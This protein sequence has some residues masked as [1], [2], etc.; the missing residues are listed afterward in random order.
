MGKFPV[1]VP[2]QRVIRPE[3]VLGW[4]KGEENHWQAI[5]WREMGEGNSSRSLACLSRYGA[6]I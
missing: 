6:G 4:E 5:L 1:D 3:M 2:R